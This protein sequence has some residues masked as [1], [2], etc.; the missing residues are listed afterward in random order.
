MEQ[1]FSYAKEFF[2]IF[3]KQKKD[4]KKTAG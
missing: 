4:L 1:L 2:W 3:L